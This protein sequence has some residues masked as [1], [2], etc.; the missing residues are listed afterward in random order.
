MSED[1]LLFHWSP[2]ARRKQIIRYGL[3]PNMRPVVSTPGWKPPYV[4]FAE[5]PSWAW[6]LS[7]YFHPEI[8]EWDLWQTSMSRLG[9]YEVVETYDQHRWHEVRSFERVFKR[10]LWY[11]ATRSS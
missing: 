3:R 8:R 6:A 5:S 9:R 4:C 1:F 10:D 7:G 2:T 11:V